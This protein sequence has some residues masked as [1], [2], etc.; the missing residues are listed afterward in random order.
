MK[1]FAARL[2]SNWKSGLTVALVS[3][4]LSVSL[5]VASGANPTVGIISAIWAGLIAAILGGSRFDIMG[6]AGA[7]SGILF[8]YAAVH[9]AGMIPLLGIVAGLFILAAW[10]FRLERYMVFIPAS[11]VHG[12]TLGV[13]L[14]IALGQRNFAFGL[15]QFFGTALAGHPDAFSN[16][17]ETFKHIGSANLPTFVAFGAF[18]V[19]LFLLVRAV[20]KI[21]G[22]II[23]TPAGIALG[24]FAKIG[25][26][27]FALMTLG[28][29]Y[30]DLRVH[31]AD[32]HWYHFSDLNRGLFA[33]AA[34]V[35]VVAILETMLCAKIADGATKTRHDK[36]KEMLALGAANVGVG[37][38][39]GLPATAVLARTAINYKSGATGKE[40]QGLN[41]V[42]VLVIA[43][44]LLSAFKFIPLAVI[45]AILVFSAVRMI[46]RKHFARMYRHDKKSFFIALLVGFITV[47]WDPSLSILIGTG[48]TLLL[49]MERLSKGQFEVGIQNAQ[50]SALDRLSGDSDDVMETAES[51]ETLVYSIKGSLAYINAQAHLARFEEAPTAQKNVIIGLRQLHFIDLDGADALDEL[52]EMLLAQGKKVMISGANAFIAAN[53][54]E[55]SMFRKLSDQGLVFERNSN[56]LAALEHSK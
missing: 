24:Y 20:P 45:A 39:G 56:A 9:G 10:A 37:I 27:P 36:R 28:D 47:Y 15:D 11:T 29:K 13:A 34:T 33:A 50:R 12:F 42:F 38:L 18:L 4:P 54:A 46:E 23:L 6:P 2:Q 8:A 51:A 25:K 16:Y 49:F 3:I 48:I 40:S 19:G 35:A 43:F 32:F 21:P 30:P 55:S 52:I 41:A 31:L 1:S 17:I 7:L 22:A 26:L 53:L 5:A 14:T 44:F